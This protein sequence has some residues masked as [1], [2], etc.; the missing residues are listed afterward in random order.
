[1]RRGRTAMFMA[2]RARRWAADGYKIGVAV[3]VATGVGV[4]VSVSDAAGVGDVQPLQSARLS[5]PQPATTSANATSNPAAETSRM[6][7]LIRTTAQ[8]GKRTPATSAREQ[9]ASLLCA[10]RWVELRARRAT[11]YGEA[12]RHRDRAAN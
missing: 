6:G 9:H 3:G 11:K 4:G 5:P 12:N 2:G 1:S 10:W 8:D 7:E